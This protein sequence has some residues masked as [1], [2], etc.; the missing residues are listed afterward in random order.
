MLMCGREFA[1]V[2]CVLGMWVRVRVRMR[3]C[4]MCV[5]VVLVDEM[6]AECKML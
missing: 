5:M 3:V 2:K 1:E 6:C 4:G